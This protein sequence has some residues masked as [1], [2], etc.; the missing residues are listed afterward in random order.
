MAIDGTIAAKPSSEIV[1]V[2]L[3]DI[4]LDG[5]TSDRTTYFCRFD[6]PATET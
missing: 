6:D 2:T 4:P 3:R 5:G 1:T